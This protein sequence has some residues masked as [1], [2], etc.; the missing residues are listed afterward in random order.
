MFK[1]RFIANTRRNGIDQ[2]IQIPPGDEPVLVTWMKGK[3]EIYGWDPISGKP[4]VISWTFSHLFRSQTTVRPNW[5]RDA[6][7]LPW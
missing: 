5:S 7:I 4:L 2:E 6:P 3:G 1:S